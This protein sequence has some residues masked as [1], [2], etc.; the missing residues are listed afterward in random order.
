M[1]K[2]ALR[3][4]PFNEKTVK[5]ISEISGNKIFLCSAVCKQQIIQTLQNTYIVTNQ[6]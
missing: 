4:M 5:H 2:D 1:A 3:N 6:E